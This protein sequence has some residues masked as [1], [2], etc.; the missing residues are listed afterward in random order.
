M[1]NGATQVNADA[2]AGQHRAAQMPKQ[3]NTVQH[4]CQNGATQ[5]NIDA[6]TGQVV[7]PE[8][9]EVS[10]EL[11]LIVLLVDCSLRSH[12]DFR[13][14]FV[15]LRSHSDFDDGENVVVDYVHPLFEVSS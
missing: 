13:F 3:G 9:F 6:K 15:C 8:V 11:L 14:F 5:G 2:K 4:R 1:P 10:D 12:I 7:E